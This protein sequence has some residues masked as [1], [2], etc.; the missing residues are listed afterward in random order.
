MPTRTRTVAALVT[1][2]AVAAVGPAAAHPTHHYQGD[3]WLRS[4]QQEAATGA[5]FVGVLAV[6]Y[7][8]TTA[9]SLPAPQAPISAT[10]DVRVNGVVRGSVS[11]AGL[12]LAAG[13]ASVAYPSDDDD[14][15]EVCERVTVAGEVHNECR[16]LPRPWNQP[17][18][19]DPVTVLIELVNEVLDPLWEPVDAEVCPALQAARAAGVPFIDADGDVTIE[20]GT[21]WDCPPYDIDWG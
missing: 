2:V 13:V 5:D 20:G 21:W 12:G 7:A 6:A 4:V 19:T 17:P 10:C 8:A 3:C 9:D 1:A 11:A 18:P 15:L 16:E 14:L